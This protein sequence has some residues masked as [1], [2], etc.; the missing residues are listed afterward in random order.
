MRAFVL[1]M[2][3]AVA[4]WCPAGCGPSITVIHEDGC[5]PSAADG[6]ADGSGGD[7]PQGNQDPPP[8]LACA[9]PL[10]LNFQP[11]C[12]TIAPSWPDGACLTQDAPNG[13]PCRS[14][15]GIC[16]AGSCAAPNAAGQCMQQI[17]AAPWPL[18]EDSGDCEDDNPCTVDSCPE[19][20]CAP[21]LHV[22]VEDGTACDAGMRCT[23]GACCDAAALP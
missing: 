18:C 8:P 11:E 3:G 23:Q 14:G 1:S 22:P 10:P 20:G 13:S 15:V 17:G 4:L 19:P 5:P 2:L 21:C 7:G 12:S 9:C 16:Y 6:G